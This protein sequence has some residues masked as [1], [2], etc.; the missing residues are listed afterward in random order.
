MFDRR[1]RLTWLLAAFALSPMA[2]DADDA[3][4]SAPASQSQDDAQTRKSSA[5]KPASAE[6]SS[7]QDEE[8]DE[9]L[10][11]FLGSVDIEEDSELL[12]YLSRNASDKAASGVSRKTARDK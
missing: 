8:V 10:L 6:S 1:G 3:Q 4:S 5:S 7:S 11:E 2:S 9:E 12:D